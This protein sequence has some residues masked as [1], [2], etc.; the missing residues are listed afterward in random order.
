MFSNISSRDAPLCARI[1]RESGVISKNRCL[2]GFF[3]EEAADEGHDVLA[4]DNEGFCGVCWFF[5]PE[6]KA[7]SL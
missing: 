7:S 1:L 6:K 4:E 2:W 5:L 3:I